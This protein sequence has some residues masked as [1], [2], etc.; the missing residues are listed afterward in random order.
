MKLPF[1]CEFECVAS[2][3]EESDAIKEIV[4]AVMQAE[5]FTNNIS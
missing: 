5:N 1:I 3:N 4:D 2:S